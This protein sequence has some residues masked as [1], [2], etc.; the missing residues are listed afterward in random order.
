MGEAMLL[1]LYRKLLPIIAV[2]VSAACIVL[3]ARLYTWQQLR[4]FVWFGLILLITLIVIVLVG[5]I[6]ITKKR[7]FK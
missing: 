7:K 2:V 1:K 3:F 4:P 6:S 5:A